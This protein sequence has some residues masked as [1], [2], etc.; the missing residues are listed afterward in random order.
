MNILGLFF[1]L[2]CFIK[3]FFYGIYE[4]SEK[5]NKI[6]GIFICALATISLLFSSTV[7]LYFYII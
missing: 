4:F 6:S 3:F 2:Y 1:V 5:R 7:I